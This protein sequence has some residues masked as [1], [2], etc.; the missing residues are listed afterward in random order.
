MSFH[1]AWVHGS[2]RLHDSDRSR[3]PTLRVR[4]GLFLSRI[5]SE[6]A[7]WPPGRWLLSQIGSFTLLHLLN[8][9]VTLQSSVARFILHAVVQVNM[10][11]RSSTQT[12]GTIRTRSH[13]K[14]ARVKTRGQLNRR[15]PDLVWQVLRHRRRQ[16]MRWSWGPRQHPQD[17][18]GAS[19]VLA[20]PMAACPQAFSPSPQPVCFPSSSGLRIRAQVD[21]ESRS[22]VRSWSPVFGFER[23]QHHR[24]EIDMSTQCLLRTGWPHSFGACYPLS[25][26]V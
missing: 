19:C 15:P 5:R 21:H 2:C 10:V 20:R 4:A 9:S 3:S 25:A 22:F 16:H 1:R 24:H 26:A 12:L 11:S 18:P 23:L 14:A 6:R 7:L 17:Y 13:H 8:T